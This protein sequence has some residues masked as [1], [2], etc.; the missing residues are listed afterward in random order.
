[1][2]VSH[3]AVK[4]FGLYFNNL[5]FLLKVRFNAEA[6]SIASA[7]MRNSDKAMSPE[8]CYC[9][10]TSALDLHVYSMSVNVFK[11]LLKTLLYPSNNVFE[12][13]IQLNTYL[14]ENAK[15]IDVVF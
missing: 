11:I 7:L 15:I 8:S 13:L 10:S 2:C 4:L 6:L 1:M 14:L 5:C 3:C 12:S 9:F